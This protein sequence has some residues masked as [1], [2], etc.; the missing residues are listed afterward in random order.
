MRDFIVVYWFEDDFD[1]TNDEMRQF[2]CSADSVDSAVEKFKS[3]C[4][5]KHSVQFVVEN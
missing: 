5:D 1:A 2:E 3:E 4:G